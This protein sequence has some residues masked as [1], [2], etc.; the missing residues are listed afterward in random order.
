MHQTTREL[1]VSRETSLVQTHI[2]HVMRIL[3]RRHGFG[4]HAETQVKQI[5]PASARAVPALP[6]MC[7]RGFSVKERSDTVFQ[8]QSIRKSCFQFAKNFPANFNK[9]RALSYFILSGLCKS[10]RTRSI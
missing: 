1:C 2:S 3:L 5:Q 10:P 6:Y 4:L 9:S 7:V 8:R